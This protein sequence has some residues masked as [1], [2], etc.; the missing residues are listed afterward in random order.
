MKDRLAFPPDFLWGTATSAHQVECGLH[1]D[2][3]E[4]E[5]RPGTVVDGTTSDAS[6]AWWTGRYEGDFT[7]AQGMHNN[8]LRLSVEWSRIEPEPGRWNAGAVSRYRTIIRA[9]RDHGLEPL[10]TLFHFTTPL[11]LAAQGGWTNSAA[12]RHFQQFVTYTVEELGDL[13]DFWCTVNEPNVYA[14]QSYLLGFWPPQRHSIA[15]TARVMRNL[16]LAHAHAYHAIHGVQPAARVGL[17][18]HVRVFDPLDPGSPLDRA[19]AWLYDWLFNGLVLTFPATG[20]LGF[21]LSPYRKVLEGYDAQDWIGLNYYS[22]DMVTLDV[23]RPGEGFARRVALPGAEFSM[24]GWG[25]VYPDGLYRC[26]KRL[27]T[28]GK[29]IYITEFGIPDNTDAQRPRM[30]LTHLAAAHRA[31]DEGIPVRGAYFWSLVD[32]FEWQAGLSA[33]FGLFGLNPATGERT[34]KRSA[35]LYREICAQGAITRDMVERY[36]PEALAQVLGA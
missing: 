32:N 34:I 31:L 19:L 30:L 27:A 20:V 2:W 7:R 18:Q 29:P 28:Y 5:R 23:R 26:L 17:A 9:A 22:R 33:R 36:A 8:A 24:E 35:E 10:V 13:V 6:C 16:L 11:W 25:E 14:S 3:S 1:N 12:I 21:P 15:A 4:W